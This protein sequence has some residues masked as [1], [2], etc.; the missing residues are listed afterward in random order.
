MPGEQ[1]EGSA[2]K[3]ARDYHVR[4]GYIPQIPAATAHLT[5]PEEVGFPT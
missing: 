3:G 2:I 1:H 4:T 5:H